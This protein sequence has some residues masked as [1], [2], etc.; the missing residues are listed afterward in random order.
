VLSDAAGV[1]RL[2]NRFVEAAGAFSCAWGVFDV[3]PN[4]LKGVEDGVAGVERAANG[5]LADGVDVTLS[6]FGAGAVKLNRLGAGAVLVPFGV[7]CAPVLIAPNKL[8]CLGVSV[9]LSLFCV[10]E[11]KPPKMFCGTAGALGVSLC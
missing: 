3:A 4:P 2:P 1:L 6:A 8:F 9:L 10:F 5:L 11:P 7:P